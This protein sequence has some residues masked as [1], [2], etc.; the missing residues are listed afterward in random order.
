M[1]RVLIEYSDGSRKK[2]MVEKTSHAHRLFCKDKTEENGV[3]TPIV[4]V[5][6]I[7]EETRRRRRRG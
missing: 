3:Y 1:P 4:S 5:T 7:H 6:T 2:A